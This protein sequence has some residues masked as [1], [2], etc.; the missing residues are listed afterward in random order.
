VPSARKLAY[1]V[2]LEEDS[3]DAGISFERLLDLA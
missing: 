3:R 2:V 1:T